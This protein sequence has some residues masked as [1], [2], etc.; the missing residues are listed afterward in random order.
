M[1][2]AVKQQLT[3][4]NQMHKVEQ[5]ADYVQ[6]VLF[7][8]SQVFCHVLH[9]AAMMPENTCEPLFF[10]SLEI[11]SLYESLKVNDTSKNRCLRL[12]N[13]RYFLKSITENVSNAHHRATLMQK[14]NKL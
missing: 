6:E 7:I 3:E 14:I 2:D 4:Y 9:I 10:L 8:Y 11:L 1:L 13:E 12:A 5:E